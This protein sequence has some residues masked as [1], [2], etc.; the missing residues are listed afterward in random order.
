MISINYRDARPIYLQVKDSLRRL[1]VTGAMPPGTK[2]PSVR[3]LAASL[4]INPNTIQRAYRELETEGYILSIA[5]KG[6]F[7]AELSRIDRTA[8]HSATDEFL[9]AAKALQALGMRTQELHLLLDDM[10]TK[11]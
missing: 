3:E 4:A 11:E 5:G 7:A 1:I 10:Q 9:R 6:S 8:L 2:L